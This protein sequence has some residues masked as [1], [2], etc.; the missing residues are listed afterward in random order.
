MRLPRPFGT[1]NDS[2][3]Q[4]GEK[5]EKLEVR[6]I[7]LKPFTFISSYGFG[8]SPEAIAHTKIV[9]FLKANHL[10]DGYGDKYRHF[11]FNNPNPSHGSPN[12]GY[13]IWVE[14]DEAVMPDGDLRKGKFEGGLY[15]VTRLTGVENIG[16]V[17]HQLVAWR[18]NSKYRHGRHQWL[19]NLFNP[20]EPDPS[21]LVFDIYLPIVG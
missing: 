18:E 12:Y 19:E 14:V 6:I 2:S 17:W 4:H 5:M 10:L 16:D 8:P 7:D 11:G 20:L 15:A 21:K 1:R 13:E 3:T 9:E